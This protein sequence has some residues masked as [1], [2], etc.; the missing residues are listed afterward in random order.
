MAV[1]EQQADPPEEPAASA[2]W[3]A[4]SAPPP[5]WAEPAMPPIGVGRRAATTGVL[6]V[7]ALALAIVSGS[8]VLRDLDAALLPYTLATLGL[9]FGLGHRLT[10]WADSRRGRRLLRGAARGPRRPLRL[11]LGRLGFR[12]L[13]AAPSRADWLAH[14]LVV[15]GCLL[16]VVLALPLVWGWVTWTA[17]A[18]P[19]AGG[20]EL[21]LWGERLVGFDPDGVLGWWLLH[22]LDLAAL[23]VLVGVAVL[24]RPSAR[25]RPTPPGGR[26][27]SRRPVLLVLL[28]VAVTGLLLTF[29]AL[30]LHGAGY[31][32][33][34]VLHLAAVVFA[35]FHLVLYLPFGA[36][37]RQARAAA[38]TGPVEAGPVEAASASEEWQP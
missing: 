34:A 31:Q 9:A 13:R 27:G 5:P 2:S 35:L 12:P 7:L 8:R 3:A 19:G 6:A 15:W 21:R 26:G 18:D 29:S 16:A 10:V 24:L 4:E 36:S 1:S 23:L 33:L 25:R 30:A 32:F 37:G 38:G 14:Q 11:L 28:A 20:Y 17:P 22:G